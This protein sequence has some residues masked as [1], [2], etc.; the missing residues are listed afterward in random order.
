MPPTAADELAPTSADELASTSA[1]ELATADK[2][3]APA[4]APA[5]LKIDNEDSIEDTWE[6]ISIS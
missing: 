4:I 6:V 3:D 1:D 5:G 2:K